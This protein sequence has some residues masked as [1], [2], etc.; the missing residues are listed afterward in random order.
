MQTGLGADCLGQQATKEQA[1]RLGEGAPR[2]EILAP[3]AGGGP[4]GAAVV[5][6]ERGQ[7][8]LPGQ[9]KLLDSYT[10]KLGG[11][12]RLVGQQGDQRLDGAGI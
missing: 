11:S 2:R 7:I 6:N 10:A 12:R 3:L 1:Q 5:I 9:Q 4:Q 8:R